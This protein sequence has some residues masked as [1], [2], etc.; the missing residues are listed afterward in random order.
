[1]EKNRHT[2]HPQAHTH[3]LLNRASV[4]SQVFDIGERSVQDFYGMNSVTL[5]WIFQSRKLVELGERL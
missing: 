1:M 5:R 3:T 2:K 4:M